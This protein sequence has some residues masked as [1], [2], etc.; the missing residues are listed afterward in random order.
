MNIYCILFN[1]GSL[2]DHLPPRVPLTVGLWATLVTQ[3]IPY[4][5]ANELVGIPPP[6]RTGGSFINALINRRSNF[7]IIH[8]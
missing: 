4:P 6:R 1:L 7:Q 2:V 8:A 3:Y 5:R